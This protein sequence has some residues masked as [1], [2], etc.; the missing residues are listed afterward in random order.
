MAD[1]WGTADMSSDREPAA[2]LLMTQPGNK[3]EAQAR[4]PLVL[5]G[6][7]RTLALLLP[8]LAAPRSQYQY[9]VLAVQEFLGKRL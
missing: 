1:S 4:I 6:K 5:N 3:A 2:A 8:D 9:G 7:D